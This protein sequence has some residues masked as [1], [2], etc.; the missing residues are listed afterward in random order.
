MCIEF[1]IQV[2][3]QQNAHVCF[4]VGM[5]LIFVEQS[6]AE[7]SASASVVYQNPTTGAGRESKCP[8]LFFPSAMVVYKSLSPNEVYVLGVK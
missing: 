2:L 8:W 1:V 3:K 5:V 4:P 6:T 7:F